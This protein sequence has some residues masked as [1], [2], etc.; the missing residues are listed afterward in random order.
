YTKSSSCCISGW[1][2]ASVSKSFICCIG[3]ANL[4]AGSG[5]IKKGLY[6]FGHFW[7]LFQAEI[8]GVRKNTDVQ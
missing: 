2:C 4:G 7:E 5:R 1:R 3:A 8:E 6:E